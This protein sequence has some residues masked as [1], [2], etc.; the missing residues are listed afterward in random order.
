MRYCKVFV[1]VGYRLATR[2][3]SYFLFAHNDPKAFHMLSSDVDPDKRVQSD[4]RQ[5]AWAAIRVTILEAVEQGHLV[6]GPDVL[7]HAF[8]G[9]IHGITMLSLATNPS[10]RL[11]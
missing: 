3:Q 10:R 4:N 11:K 6:G 2:C 7:A 1:L 8:W 5:R 9:A